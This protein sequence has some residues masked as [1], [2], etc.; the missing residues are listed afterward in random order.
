MATRRFLRPPES[1][2][3]RAAQHDQYELALATVITPFGAGHV[4]MYGVLLGAGIAFLGRALAGTL[5]AHRFLGSAGVAIGTSTVLAAAVS[6][7]GTL[8]SSSRAST[9]LIK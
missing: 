4:L 3:I 5:L 1:V 8:E 9:I 6:I 7:V 2:D